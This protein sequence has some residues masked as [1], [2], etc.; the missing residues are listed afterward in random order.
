MNWYLAKLVYRINYSNTECPGEF[1]EQLRLIVAEDDL[2]AFQKARLLGD[3]E[4]YMQVNANCLLV[5]WKF[6]DVSELHKM[7]TLTDGAE[8]YSQISIQEN[9]DTYIRNI[10]ERALQL[11]D[12]A[13]E[14][15]TGS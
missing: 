12:H 3:K 11:Y 15:F 13:V 4:G 2:H 5:Q 8:M 10:R 1:D 9:A 6:I 14:H 7:D